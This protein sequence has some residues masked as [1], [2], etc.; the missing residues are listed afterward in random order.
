MIFSILV[1]QLYFYS[2]NFQKKFIFSI[3]LSQL[4]FCPIN[5]LKF[6]IFSTLVYCLDFVQ[7]SV[8][9]LLIKAYFDI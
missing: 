5:C 4:Y 7:S 3:L 8:V 2:T 6:S 9:Y 1:S